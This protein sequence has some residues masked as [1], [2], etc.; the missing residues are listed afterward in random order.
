MAIANLTLN[1]KT[2][3]YASDQ[4]GIITWNELSGGIPTGFSKATLALREPNGKPNSVYRLEMHL[5]MPTV[6][7]ADSECAC[8]GEVLRNEAGRVIVEIPTT[9]TT[10]ER[11]DYGLRLKDLL[12]NAQVQAALASLTRPG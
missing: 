11:T 5:T 8:T 12:A 10:A 1:T 7:A 9:G 6:A 4:A 3:T 2:Y